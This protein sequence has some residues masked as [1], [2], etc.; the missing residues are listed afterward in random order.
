MEALI[1][2]TV[3]VRYQA[4][5]EFSV[6]LY[7]FTETGNFTVP[8]FYILRSTGGFLRDGFIQINVLPAEKWIH[9]EFSHVSDHDTNARVVRPPGWRKPTMAKCRKTAVFALYTMKR[10]SGSTGFKKATRARTT[11][12]Q[13]NFYI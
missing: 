12:W 10:I 7:P 9:D 13:L 6:M 1:I 3:R 11:Y 4:F 8:L 2:S 5:F